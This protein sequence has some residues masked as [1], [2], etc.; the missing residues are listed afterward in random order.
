MHA[1]HADVSC[2]LG[3]TR[4]LKML[5]RFYWLVG[6]EACNKWWVRRCL[7]CKARKTSRQTIRWPTLSI[8]LPNSP[9]ISVSIDYFGPLPITARGNS[10]ILLFT[11]RFS[12][13]P[14]MFAATAAEFTAEGTANVLVNRFIPLW[15]CPSNLLSDNGLEFCAHLATAV[16]KLLGIHKLT[17]SV[18]HPSGKSSVERVN[19]TMAQMLAMVCNNSD[20]SLN[21]KMT[22]THTFPT[23]NMPLITPLARRQASLPMKYISDA[24]HASLSPSSTA[25]TAEPIRASTTT[26]SSI[27]TLSENGNNAPTSSCGNSIP[28]Q[29]LV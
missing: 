8:P 24:Y 7:K 22:G 4:T 27:A 26:V 23:S 29:S 15:G 17:T 11:D 25:P 2:H 6:M 10:Y 18:Y 9:G 16:Y 12:R 3:V 13:R 28:S 5:E 1:C 19:H 20:F 14:D 21:T